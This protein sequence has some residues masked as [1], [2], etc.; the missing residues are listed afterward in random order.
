[1]A[2]ALFSPGAFA[3]RLS[4]AAVCGKRPPRLLYSVAEGIVIK[5]SKTNESADIEYFRRSGTL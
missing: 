2:F 3:D 4:C 1:M 5:R